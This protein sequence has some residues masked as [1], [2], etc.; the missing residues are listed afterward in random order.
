MRPVVI[1]ELEEAIAK[2]NA[3]ATFEEAVKDI[4]HELL[5]QTPDGLPYSIWQI[6]EHIRLAQWDILDFCR[7][8]HYK[9]MNWPDDYWPKEKAP[10]QKGDFWKSVNQL[11][12]DRK[13]FIELLRKAG[14]E[15]LYTPL[16]HGDGQNLFRE[17]L[18][19]IDHNSYHVGEIIVLRRLLGDWK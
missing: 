9:S 18:L 10:A 6:V 14:D 16:A 7:N 13:A 2:G 4:P 8:P 12:A 5:G 19:I 3:H 11:L 17:A 1:K 15:E